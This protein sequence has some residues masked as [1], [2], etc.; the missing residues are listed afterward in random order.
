[1]GGKRGG[2]KSNHGWVLVGGGVKFLG[3][4]VVGG[5]CDSSDT[6]IKGKVP[7]A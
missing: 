6:R 7:R 1:M 3:T 2:S 5:K 4:E